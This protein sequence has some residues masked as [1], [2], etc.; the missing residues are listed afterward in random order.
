MQ[1]FCTS[2]KLKVYL[3][4]VSLSTHFEAYLLTRDH[5]GGTGKNSNT[6]L[7]TQVPRG[8]LLTAASVCSRQMKEE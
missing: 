5:I 7:R 3:K 2:K 1:S 8:E 6:S 4:I